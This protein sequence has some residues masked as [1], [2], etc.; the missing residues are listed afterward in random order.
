MPLFVAGLSHKNAP[1]ELRERLA[2]EEDKLRELL[3]DI[4]A[5]GAV[6]EALVLSTCNRVEVYGVAAV[7][8]EARAVAFR[9]LCAHRG[10]GLTAIEPLLYTHLE[11]EAGRHP[12]RGAASPDPMVSAEPRV[13]RRGQDA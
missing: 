11:A 1:I 9:H 13:R 4:A 3:R 7:P 10:V 2:V 8:G 12:L 6:D 5:T